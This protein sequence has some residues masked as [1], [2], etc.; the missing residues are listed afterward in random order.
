MF[1]FH[2]RFPPAPLTTAESSSGGGGKSNVRLVS[3]NSG[4]TSFV[5]MTASMMTSFGLLQADETAVDEAVT[6]ALNV[7]PAGEVQ[8]DHNGKETPTQYHVSDDDQGAGVRE[9]GEGGNAAECLQDP[10]LLQSPS[11]AQF[12][13]ASALLWQAGMGVSPSGDEVDPECTRLSR[14]HRK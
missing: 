2:L 3:A 1:L 13:A 11:Y 5:N 4:E 9:S 10:G 12:F 14:L 6:V 8:D 7:L